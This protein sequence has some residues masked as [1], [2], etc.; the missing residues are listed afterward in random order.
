MSQFFKI[1]K[2][3]ELPKLRLELIHDGHADYWK[4]YAAL[5]A[6]EY[7]TFSMWNK[8]T[9][10][11]KIA[12][13]KAEIVPDE[14]SGC[15]ERYLL[16]YS[17]NKRDTN[18]SGRY[19]GQFKITFSDNIIMDEITF[20]AGELIVPIHEDLYIGISDAGLKR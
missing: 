14:E 1:N 19:V 10:I 13:A 15:E 3:S 12:N 11:Y 4:C 16:Q 17:W 18:E 20:P 8:E 5:Q 7:I 9:G 2:G 6:A